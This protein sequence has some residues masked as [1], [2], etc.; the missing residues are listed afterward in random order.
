MA[1]KWHQLFSHIE[2]VDQCVEASIEDNCGEVALNEE[3]EARRVVDNLF[4]QLDCKERH[5]GRVRERDEERK[6]SGRERD[7]GR[8]EGREKRE[9]KGVREEWRG[10]KRV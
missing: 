1:V 6:R 9:M 3:P 5:G 8:E 2:A 4:G 10:S 7:E